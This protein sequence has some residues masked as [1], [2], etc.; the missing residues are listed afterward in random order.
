MSFS[1]F[2]SHGSV[3]K[4]IEWISLQRKMESTVPLKK[5]I[6][7]AMLRFDLS[8]KDSEFLVSFY[9]EEAQRNET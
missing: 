6:N 7:D 1:E 9:R 8:P 5:L 4:A 3:K 2:S